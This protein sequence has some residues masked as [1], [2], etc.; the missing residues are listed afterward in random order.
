MSRFHPLSG[1]IRHDNVISAKGG[2][3]YDSGMESFWYKGCEICPDADGSAPM[4]GA[5]C[6]V[7]TLVNGTNGR[8]YQSFVLCDLDHGTACVDDVQ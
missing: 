5:N 6:A 3:C 2:V 1:H 8:E 4:N 7:A